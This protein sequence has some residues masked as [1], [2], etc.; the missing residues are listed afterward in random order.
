M[1][2]KLIVFEGGEGGGKSTQLQRLKDWLLANPFWARRDGPAPS[3][4]TTREPGGTALG[5]QLR[6]LLLN[7]QDTAEVAIA[8]RSELLLYAADRAQHVAEF[9]APHLEQGDL[10]LCDR[11]TAST[12]AYQGYGRGLDLDLI[13]QL[14]QIATV[15]VTSD[16]T[17]WLDLDVSIGLERVRQRGETFDRMEIGEIAFHQRIRDGFTAIAAQQPTMVQIDAARNPDT[18]AAHIQAVMQEYLQQWYPPLSQN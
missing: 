4:V 17:L 1:Q 18:V 15:G 13:E 2:G 8:N 16:L 5:G 7:T 11:Y 3:V 6:A 9:I 10:V 14:N 12:V